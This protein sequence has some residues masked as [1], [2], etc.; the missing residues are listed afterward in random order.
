MFVNGE[1]IDPESELDP[2]TPNAVRLL[3]M[4]VKEGE[5]FSPV[6]VDKLF[7]FA[8]DLL[9]LTRKKADYHQA[10]RAELVTAMRLFKD[11]YG[12]IVGENPPLSVDFYYITKKDVEPNQDCNSSA[13][14]VSRRSRSISIR[15]NVTFIL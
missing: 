12:I 7:F 1:L 3:I 10:Y 4:Q 8:D 6:S 9:D 2:K 11:K 15:R 13:E 14:K 5:G